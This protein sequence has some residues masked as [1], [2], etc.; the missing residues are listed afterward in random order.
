MQYRHGMQYYTYRTFSFAIYN[1]ALDGKSRLFRDD[2][3]EDVK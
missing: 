1:I 3:E 2:V